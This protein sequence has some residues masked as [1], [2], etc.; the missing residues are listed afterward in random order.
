VTHPDPSAFLDA[1]AVIDCA[2]PTLVE[3]ARQLAA[4]GPD[5]NAIARATFEFVRDRISHSGDAHA[6]VV[7]CRASEVLAAGTGWCFAKSHLLAALLRANGIPA[8]LCYQR[9]AKDAVDGEFTLHGLNAVW[10]EDFGWYRC[11]PRG[12]KP[13]VSTA[14]AP[15]VERLAW[16]MREPGEVLFS[17]ILPRPL[18]VIVDYLQNTHGWQAAIDALPDAETLPW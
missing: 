13:G 18:P 14:F 8:G 11:D 5:K 7:T 16:P 2:H 6:E 12:D 15:P 17:A 1:C 9:L 10:L 3:Q 4:A